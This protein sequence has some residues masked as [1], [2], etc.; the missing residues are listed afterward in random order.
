MA[1]SGVIVVDRGKELDLSSCSMVELEIELHQV[2]QAMHAAGLPRGAATVETEI[3]ALREVA[4]LS[5]RRRAILAEVSHRRAALASWRADQDQ[6]D[7]IT[8]GDDSV[9]DQ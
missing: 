8:G 1:D 4:I 5:A 2:S 3:A 7:V 6:L 9:A